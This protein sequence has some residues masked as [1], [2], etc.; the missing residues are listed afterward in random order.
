MIFLNLKDGMK[1]VELPPEAQWA[2]GFGVIAED[3]DGDRNQDLFI[4][5]NFFAT[6]PEYSRCDAGRG[7]LMLGDGHGGF[8]AIAAS[9]SGVVAYG[10]QRA[11][12]VSDFNRDGRMDLAIGQNKAQ[13]KLLLN[14][15]GV[16]GIRVRLKGPTQ[17]PA[18]VGAKVTLQITEN[19][20]LT[21]EVQSGSGYWAVNS[22]VL[23]LPKLGRAH[24][25]TVAWPSG[26][27]VN[28][29]IPGDIRE[30]QL[31]ESGEATFL[32]AR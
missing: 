10:E 19:H 2:P 31:Q 1:P 26:R 4:A 13:T 22:S 11:C 15:T 29:K 16:A 3:F 27:A 30:L 8:E 28:Y 17:N 6:N 12:A 23:I 32:K 5:Q 18:A 20:T 9:Q 7:L 21:K 24:E 14:N 25:L